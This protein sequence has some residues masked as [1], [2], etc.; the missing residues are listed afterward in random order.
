MVFDAH[1][2]AFEFFGG[3]P[4]RRI[5]WRRLRGHDVAHE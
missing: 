2:K 3:V 4:R 5:A 1:G